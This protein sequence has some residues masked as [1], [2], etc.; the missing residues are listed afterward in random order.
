[1]GAAACGIGS[2]PL[3]CSEFLAPVLGAVGA[4]DGLLREVARSVRRGA[5]GDDDRADLLGLLA[6][7]AVLRAFER[8]AASGEVAA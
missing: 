5:A 4:N 7:R 1:V 2:V 8:S 6:A 3:D